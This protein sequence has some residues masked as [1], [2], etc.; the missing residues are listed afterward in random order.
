MWLDYQ[1]YQEL[2]YS[3]SPSNVS[4][5][6]DIY[7]T[8]IG[9]TS[10]LSKSFYG[11]FNFGLPVAFFDAALLWDFIVDYSGDF[12]GALQRR[13]PFDTNKKI[14]SWSWMGWYA[15]LDTTPIQAR[16]GPKIKDSYGDVPDKHVGL[17]RLTPIVKWY[18]ISVTGEQQAVESTWDKYRQLDISDNLKL[19]QGW[20]RH[21]N[22][23]Q[24]ETQYYT[25]THAPGIDFMYPFPLIH[26]PPPLSKSVLPS[27]II[28]CRAQRCFLTVQ[29]TRHQ[30]YTTKL[31][32]EYGKS[33]GYIRCIKAPT[34][35]IIS[36][37][38]PSLNPDLEITV[39]RTFSQR[40]E[41]VAISLGTCTWRDYLS[42]DE[43][44]S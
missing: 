35:E 36:H 40:V 16:I 43:R 13:V 31:L 37:I 28:G 19:P 3:Y 8:F 42:Y 30:K 20:T 15:M 34:P 38:E 33:V 23:P 21:Q 6:E 32:D 44:A 2:V 17:N 1:A 10:T 22:H 26:D 41:L 25:T 11:G 7:N 9:I 27:S 4:V 14:P 12:D 18:T 24:E 29:P 5:P 39:P